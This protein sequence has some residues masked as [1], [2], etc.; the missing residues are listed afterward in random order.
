[1]STTSAGAARGLNVAAG[2]LSTTPP[3]HGGRGY[4]HASTRAP[5]GSIAM[6]G[7]DVIRQFFGAM[8]S[9]NMEAAKTLVHEDFVMEW[10]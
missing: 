8:A 9:G 7:G 2:E 10:P 1:M 3:G 4:A 6:S 5:G